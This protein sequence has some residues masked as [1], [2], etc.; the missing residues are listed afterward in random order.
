MQMIDRTN[1]IRNK[2]KAWSSVQTRS[3]S[4]IK[5]AQITDIFRTFRC[6]N[7][8]ILNRQPSKSVNRKGEKEERKVKPLQ[9]RQNAGFNLPIT[10]FSFLV[11]MLV[12]NTSRIR[13]I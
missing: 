7:L 8:G 12:G 13:S 1:D 11:C 2:V 9:T 4:L 3:L 6:L 10:C 5:H